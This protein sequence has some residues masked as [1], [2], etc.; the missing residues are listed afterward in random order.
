[1]LD[2]FFI[3]AIPSNAETGTYHLGLVALSYLVA[4]LASYTAFT[5]TN[6]QIAEPNAKL[7]RYWHWGGAFAMGA[8]IWSMHFIGM[9]AF[10]MD[11]LHEYNL[12]LTF[13]SMLAAI[14]VAYFVLAIARKTS[15]RWPLLA[16]SAVLLGLGICIM[17]YAGMAAMILDGEIRYLADVFALSVAI[18][19]G[20]S[21]AALWLLFNLTQHTFKHTKL[22][23]ALSSLVMGAAIC[24]MHYS[25][26]AA[27]VF[28][29]FADC[30]YA[31]DQSFENLALIICGVTV[32]ILLV[33]H[34]VESLV[35]VLSFKDMGHKVFVHLTVLM[36]LWAGAYAI[37]YQSLQQHLTDQREHIVLLNTAGLQRML[38]QSY[39]SKVIAADSMENGENQD[40]NTAALQASAL[41]NSMIMRN[42][43]SFAVGGMAHSTADGKE[44]VE[45]DALH[46]P[47][48]KE[49]L[50]TAVDA[51]ED[52][53]INLDKLTG[54]DINHNH[55]P[56]SELLIKADHAVNAQDTLAR[57]VQ[58]GLEK[59]TAAISKSQF[60]S[61]FL[62]LSVFVITL[63]YIYYYISIPL[64]KATR[65]LQHHRDNLQKMVEEQTKDVV[66]AK[67]EAERANQ[68]K[69]EFL[70]NMSHELRTPMHSIISFSRQGIQRKDRWSGD[71]QAENLALIQESGKRLLGLIN[72]LLDLSKLEAGAAT[73]EMSQASLPQSVQNVGNHLRAMLEEKNIVLHVQDPTHFPELVYD[74]DK[75]EQ[76]IINLLS[77]AFKF[78]PEGGIIHV[79]FFTSEHQA[80][81]RVIDTG[82][83]IPEAEIQSIFDKFIQSSQTKTGA[84]GTG[85]GLAICREIIEEGHGGSLWV[86]NNLPGQ[87]ATFSFTLPIQPG[88]SA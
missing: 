36:L 21:G 22:Y 69:S 32:L 85:L 76:V 9:L 6:R 87:G 27:T 26:M 45:I 72:N 30:R 71:E 80:G 64:S 66:I 73:Y 61:I 84:G 44:M 40:D 2:S 86:E 50:K 39:A 70:A 58:D 53:R 81:L 16:G 15:L 1:M 62:Y 42:F 48:A 11:M 4:C 17:H 38:M 82:P 13:V 60:Y 77:N 52:T 57:A 88:D 14:L 34:F 31:P 23:I 83:G 49:A 8:G 54:P 67:E 29:P 25:G 24:G 37:S 59:E 7:K 55:L 63:L 12:P 56:L 35:E 3:T 33:T 74:A 75:I 28:I 65:E 19:I 5:L 51:W 10:K 20:A 47:Q 68:L 79:E 43:A 41:I 46:F 78:T 18:A